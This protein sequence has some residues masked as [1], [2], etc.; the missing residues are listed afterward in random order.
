MNPTIV[1]IG[2][3]A[4][5][6]YGVFIVGGA[7]LAAWFSG[8]YAA[9]GGDDPDHIWNILAWSLIGGIIGARLYH[10]F[11]SPADGLGWEY[12]RENPLDIINF[13][14]GG[15]RGLGIYGGLVGG[16]LAVY[17][18][19]RINKL[20][21]V[22]FL[23]YIAPNVLI[24]QALGRLGNWVNQELYGPP[25][26]RPWAFY[27]NPEFPCQPPPMML[28]PGV[29]PCAAP[30]ITDATRLWY[31]NNGYHPTFFYE[32]LWN[33]AMFCLL[34]L[35]I[36][37]FGERLRRGDGSLLYL[38]AYGAGRYWVEMFRPDAWVI[39]QMATAQWIGLACVVVGV[40]LLIVRHAGWSWRDHPEESL[41]HMSGFVTELEEDGEGMQPPHADL[42]TVQ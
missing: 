32:A 23:D 33:V 37:R 2:P 28:P 14:N 38:I 31:A 13:W 25:T 15:L 34:A 36:W 11:S 24:A 41:G 18:Y 35:I 26:S 8:L 40:I 5:N 19:C 6:W 1:E 30:N 27:I 12:Y 21:T 39:G 29:Q 17:I 9:R 10:V 7:V 4:L 42:P 16:A 20:N 3:F 22:R